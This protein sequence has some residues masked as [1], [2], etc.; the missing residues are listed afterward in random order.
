MSRAYLRFQ[1]HRILISRPAVNLSICIYLAWIDYLF[2][3]KK[4]AMLYLELHSTSQ[5]IQLQR[6]L[7]FSVDQYNKCRFKK[8]IKTELCDVC[9][10]WVHIIRMRWR[11]V[12]LQKHFFIESKSETTWKNWHIHIDS[13]AQSGHSKTLDLKKS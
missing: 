9:N 4:T 2:R 11:E 8:Q 5:Q 1:S 12:Y 7:W 6:G 3:K 10:N 13:A